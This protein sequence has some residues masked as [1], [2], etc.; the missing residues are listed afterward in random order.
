MITEILGIGFAVGAKEWVL[1]TGGGNIKREEVEMAVKTIMVGEETKE[2]RN[3]A[4][5]LKEMAR[6]TV[7]EGGSSHSDLND[8]I[9]ELDLFHSSG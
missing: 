5:G 4:K 8:L 9:Q 2:R 3:R 7:E 1:G 6:K